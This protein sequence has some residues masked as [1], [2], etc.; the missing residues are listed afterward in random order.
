MDNHGFLHKLKNN[1][2][3]LFGLITILFL[4]F[5]AVF[6][7]LII[8][9]KTP[10]ANSQISEIALA[11]PFTKTLILK[12][13]LGLK[14]NNNFFW[15]LTGKPRSYTESAIRDYTFNDNDLYIELIN[16]GQKFIQYSQI[17]KAIDFAKL[18]SKEEIK[19]FIETNHIYSK[20]FLF[21]TDRFGRSM[22]SRLILGIRISLIA[23]FLAVI[24]SLFIGIFLG[25]VGGYFGGW[26]D[27]IVMYL[28]NVTWSI[29]TLLLVFAIV[30]AL[31]RGL[32]VIFLA[33]GLTMW[34][35]VARITRGQVIKVKEQLFVTAARSLGLNDIQIIRK[36]ILPNIVGPILVITAANFATA[37]LIE[38][39]LSYLGFGINPPTPSLGNM[40]NENYGYALG[41]NVFIAVV[42]ALFIMIL[43]LAF[44][45]L[46][47]GLRDI[48]DV[49]D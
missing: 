13:D 15:W 6:G 48:F 42:P 41:G 33:V 23:G 3:A 46:G 30:L 18:D 29:P 37:I 17:L 47:T 26:I 22:L 11:K 28:I 25:A 19:I 27:T 38:A 49:K 20:T 2:G 31:G 14:Q 35:D 1:K 5:L 7:Y 10:D 16:G 40:L 12:Q 32:G 24:V 21:G 39:G 8:G 45:L 44:N 9:D 36:H 43:V 34:V 4:S